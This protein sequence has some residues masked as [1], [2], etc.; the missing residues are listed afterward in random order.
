MR[1]I[2]VQLIKLLV[3]AAM[4][5][6]ALAGCGVRK[7][8][9]KTVLQT[10]TLNDSLSNRHTVSSL[11]TDYYGDSL[12]GVF[13]VAD[14]TGTDSG[15]FTS[16]G[17]KVKLKVT[18]GKPG[19]KVNYTAEAVPV[20]RSKLTVSSEENTQVRRAQ[21]VSQ[22]TEKQLSV[23]RPPV[24][25]WLAAVVAAALLIWWVIEKLL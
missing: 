23:K 15:E 20:A 11:Q 13:A 10:V 12:T 2:Q 9:V 16:N 5:I 8:A 19:T 17:I 24:W 22:T 4:L 18:G 1:P 6:L 14:S 3:F 25:V 21:S 7:K